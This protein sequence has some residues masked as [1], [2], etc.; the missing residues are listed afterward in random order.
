MADIIELRPRVRVPLPAPAVTPPEPPVRTPALPRRSSRWAVLA[1]LA[2]W[3]APVGLALPLTLLFRTSGGLAPQAEAMPAAATA[4]M[5]AAP[6]APARALADLMR[7][8]SC[9]APMLCR[10]P[11]QAAG[12]WGQ[13][14]AADW[15]KVVAAATAAR[16]APAAPRPP[17]PRSLAPS[18][19]GPPPPP[20][21][22]AATD[23]LAAL[24]PPDRAAAVLAPKRGWESAAVVPATEPPGRAGLVTRL[25]P[26]TATGIVARSTMPFARPLAV[27]PAPRVVA[28]APSAVIVPARPVQSGRTLS[29][30]PDAAAARRLARVGGGTT[31]SDATQP[32]MRAGDA[33]STPVTAADAGARRRPWMAGR[34]AM[35]G[36]PGIAVAS[37]WPRRWSGRGEAVALRP[38]ADPERWARRAAARADGVPLRRM[39]RAPVVAAGG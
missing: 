27:V 34:G 17:A 32:M 35:T 15:E 22:P 18:L 31:S 39:M 25:D 21:A 7:E 19:A 24:L 5:A 23:R 13:A 37:A 30:N 33:G 10:Q 8:A 3:L 26:A 14:Q 4:T 38:V 6:A 11:G 9:A 12:L 36:S 29:W 28:P 2:V 16:P 1:I 20:A